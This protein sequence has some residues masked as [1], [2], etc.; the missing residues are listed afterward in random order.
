MYHFQGIPLPAN[1]QVH[2]R[3]EAGII[4][5]STRSSVYA[6]SWHH[7]VCGM[8][9]HHPICGP[10]RSASEQSDELPELLAMVCQSDAASTHAFHYRLPAFNAH[11]DISNEIRKVQ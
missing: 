11:L 8:E 1:R 7:F 4:Q 3:V 2:F 6:R 5:T 9:E 10:Y